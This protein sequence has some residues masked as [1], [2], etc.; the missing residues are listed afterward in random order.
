MHKRLLI[1]NFDIMI[2]SMIKI[3]NKMILLNKFKTF[4]NSNECRKID[5]IRLI[6]L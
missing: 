5:L 6:N 1:I 4:E 3:E 2:T